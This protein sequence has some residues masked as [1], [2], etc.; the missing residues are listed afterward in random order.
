MGCLSLQ[1]KHKNEQSCHIHAHTTDISV[2]V[3][4]R[5]LTSMSRVLNPGALMLASVPLRPRL[6]QWLRRDMITRAR[7]RSQ[8][9]PFVRLSPATKALR[10]PLSPLMTAVTFS[11]AEI[12]SCKNSTELRPAEDSGGPSN[13]L[14]AAALAPMTHPS[15][16]GPLDSS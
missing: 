15:P 10:L 8:R 6:S 13:L 11:R 7:P 5:I 4:A 14:S 3:S 1:H 12:S 9:G 16:R 2:A